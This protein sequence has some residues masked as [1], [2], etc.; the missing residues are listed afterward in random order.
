MVKFSARACSVFLYSFVVIVCVGCTPPYFGTVYISN[1]VITAEDPNAFLSLTYKGQG[2]RDV[3]DRRVGAW[4]V[5]NAFLFD[6]HYTDSVTIEVQVNPEFGS[7]TDARNVSLP[8]AESLGTLPK[9]LREDI[10]DLEIHGGNEVAGGNTWTKTV[11]IHSLYG[12]EL[13]RTGFLEEVLLHEAS[14]VA[15]DGDYAETPAWGE[16]MA[17]DDGRISRHASLSLGEDLTESFGAYY[18]LRYKSDRISK[19]DQ[20]IINNTIPARLSFF[21]ALN[22]DFSQ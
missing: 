10:Y 19:T 12:D 22:L 14:H 15:L 17:S 13:M 16:A 5:V 7:V 18:A 11:H 3:F 4:G 21:D 9:V 8:I 1:D 2:N 20:T 6:A